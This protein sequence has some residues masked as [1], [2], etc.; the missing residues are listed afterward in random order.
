M[1]QNTDGESSQNLSPDK[2]SPKA[3]NRPAS[4]RDNKSQKE[5]YHEAIGRAKNDKKN[6][7]NKNISPQKTTSQF[8]KPNENLFDNHKMEVVEKTIDLNVDCQ[9]EFGKTKGL[10]RKYE[11]TTRY[12]TKMILEKITIR[13]EIVTDWIS[14][15]T[16]RASMEK[17]GQPK[18]KI[19]WQ[20]LAFI[21]EFVIKFCIPID[22]L[23]KMI[24]FSDYRFSS[25]RI[26]GYLEKA[27]EILLPIYLYLA[28]LLSE[29]ALLNGDDSRTNVVEIRR[30]IKDGTL[31]SED[32]KLDEL[33]K[34]VNDALPRISKIRSGKRDKKQL[35]ISTLIGKS[36]SFDAR[37]TIY[38]FR[39]HVGDLGNLIGQ[40][41]SLRRPKN[42]HLKLVTDLLTANKPDPWIEKKFNIK[43]FGCS[44]HARRPFYRFR[45]RDP[46]LCY[47]MLR[48]FSILAKVELKI[49]YLGRSE[50]NILYFR[51]K[52]SDKIWK[53]IK[54]KCSKVIEEK[55][56]P[57]SSSLYDACLYILNHYEKLTKYI[58]HPEVDSHNNIS[59]RVLRADKIMLVSSKFRVTEKGRVIIDILRT[60]TMTCSAAGVPVSKY[61][62]YT[63]THRK[64]IEDHPENFTPFA[65]AKLLD[66]IN[67]SKAI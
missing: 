49:D 34:K 32:E 11:T 27:A 46:E 18:S 37:S 67:Y 52:Y 7:E 28:E 33:V 41:L 42:K 64:L 35:S 59:E 6:C 39:T 23:S 21:V 47:F 26:C 38:F 19:T 17:I 4:N 5:K 56:W 16:A 24:S 62:L 15:K 43:Y 48:A 10:H 50:K 61:L 44:A 57:P 55:N 2:D 25:G 58:N 1:Q 63:F 66:E 8:E 40:L 36:D 30:K 13:R 60:I 9:V 14:G 31:G 22:R 51:R 54:N 12:Q 53:I 29:S 65:Y 45:D 3:H 20:M